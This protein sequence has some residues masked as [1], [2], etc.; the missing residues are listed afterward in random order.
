MESHVQLNAVGKPLKWVSSRSPSM[1]THKYAVQAPRVAS[2]DGGV[3][4]IATSTAINKIKAAVLQLLP[5]N[6]ELSYFAREYRLPKYA[7]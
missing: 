3:P 5:R 2:R 4:E 7:W 6:R 1:A